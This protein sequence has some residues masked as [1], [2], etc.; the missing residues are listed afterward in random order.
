MCFYSFSLPL[1]MP[2][3]KPATPQANL[4]AIETR[5][6][7]QAALQDATGLGSLQNEALD[8][9]WP[10]SEDLPGG[11]PRK[12]QRKA[13]SE[14]QEGPQVETCVV[15]AAYP[16]ETWPLA[17]LPLGEVEAALP[18]GDAGAS[19]SA[20]APLETGM[21]EQRPPQCAAQRDG[22]SDGAASGSR[23]GTLCLRLAAGDDAEDAA[24]GTFVAEN[25]DGDCVGAVRVWQLMLTN[26]AS[27]AA[28]CGANEPSVTVLFEPN[29]L[30]LT[31]L[32]GCRSTWSQQ[33]SRRSG[34]ELLHCTRA[35]VL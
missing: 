22:S 28:P 27:S 3:R 30:K 35:G 16:E 9:A 18:A 32:E 23:V 5:P 24:V 20:A 21:R 25:S 13:K 19:N 17:R 1:T 8:P 15:W 34:G 11:R 14:R 2:R 26:I 33:T 29:R 7:Y 6:A 10:P 12:R 31:T 4:G